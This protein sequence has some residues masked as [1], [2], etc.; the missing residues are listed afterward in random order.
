MT[1]TKIST[2][3]EMNGFL[4]RADHFHDT[5]IRE[6]SIVARGYVDA[7]YSLHG[8]L[9]PFD[10]RVFLQTQFSD[11]PGIELRFDE[12]TR[13]CVYPPYD[14]A[15]SGIVEEGR[16]RFSFT[17]LRDEE[18]QVVASAM[19]YRFLDSSCLGTGHLLTQGET[20]E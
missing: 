10:A 7:E 18:L 12:V 8:D 13:F 9:D 5:I 17:P 11:M 20:G 19:R 15:P 14:L 3:K 16:V 6:I 4:S 2:N 1:M